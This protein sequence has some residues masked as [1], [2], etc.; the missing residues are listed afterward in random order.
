MTNAVRKAFYFLIF[1]G[2]LLLA[3]KIIPEN[4][5]CQLPL[6]LDRLS[7]NNYIDYVPKKCPKSMILVHTY[8]SKSPAI[9]LSLSYSLILAGAMGA[10]GRRFESC[11]PRSV[12][13]VSLSF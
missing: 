13:A 7:I 11:H 9:A 10:L 12:I 6:I 3:K 2:F 4:K 1:I 8:F 5:Y